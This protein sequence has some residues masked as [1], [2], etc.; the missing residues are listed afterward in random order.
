MDGPP[1]LVSRCGLVVNGLAQQI[2]DPAQAF[3]AYRN[4][5]GGAGVSGFHAPLQAIGGGHGDT[6][7]HVVTDVLRHFRGDRS[8]SA[9]NMNGAEQR[10][11]LIV[12]ESNIKN[13]THDLDH[14]SLVIGH[15][16]QLLVIGIGH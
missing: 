10:G 2:E 12:G 16:I 13:R 11:K 3:L 1:L 14:C 9:G 4:G 15:R 8:V 6:A 5:D 7:H